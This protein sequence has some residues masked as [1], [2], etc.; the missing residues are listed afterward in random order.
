MIVNNYIKFTELNMTSLDLFITY[1]LFCDGTL[2]DA[3]IQ[4]F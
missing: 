4:G 1:D 3:A 2:R